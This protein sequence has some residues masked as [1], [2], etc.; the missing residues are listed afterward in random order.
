MLLRLLASRLMGRGSWEEPEVGV[1]APE[2]EIQDKAADQHLGDN[3]VA[4]VKGSHFEKRPDLPL[5]TK[6]SWLFGLQH[7]DYD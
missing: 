5:A 3:P 1:S 7:I 6:V 2:D 4:S